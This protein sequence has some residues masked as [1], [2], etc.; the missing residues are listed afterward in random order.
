[1]VIQDFKLAFLNV[2]RHTRRS[3]MTISVGGVGVFSVLMIAGFINA[4]FM[5]LRESII[6]SGIGHIEVRTV[7]S[8]NEFEE[9][10]L[11]FGLD[12]EMR[13][14]LEEFIL[15]Q[16]GVYRILPR[17][18]FE[19]LVSNGDRSI[20]FLG[21]GLNWESEQ[22]FTRIFS[23]YSGMVSGRELEGG[24]FYHGILGEGLANDL[25]VEA[26]QDVT[27]LVNSTETGL[28][29]IDIDVV[30]LYRTGIPE[31][32]KRL[33]YISLGLAQELLLTDKISSI[34]VGLEGI[35]VEEEERALQS[36][37]RGEFSD[38]AVRKWDEIDVFY[39]AVRSL[40]TN[41]FLVISLILGLVVVLSTSTTMIMCVLER[42][43]EMATLRA[44]GFS[45]TNLSLLFCLEGGLLGLFGGIFGV[46]AAWI[47]GDMI[48]GINIMM[49][50]PPGRDFPYP[51]QFIITKEMFIAV[52]LINPV[53][54]S[55]SSF[56]PS[57]RATRGN[58]AE[59]LQVQ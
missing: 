16:E 19:G 38:L 49:P 59:S 22:D 18:D 9:E 6:H 25:G 43:K 29:V 39:P 41:I 37:L 56:L 26:G 36:R 7:E 34:S 33:V 52:V 12:S 53:L 20:V 32:D 44:F 11:E 57:L 58:I 4:S 46:I 54:C 40:Y 48:N 50:P 23:L 14:K 47:L 51:L 31:Y 28:N 35:G 30:G 45:R 17:I 5:G 27:L 24:D 2:L 3:L 21:K 13:G 8:L 55:I 42:Q 10:T 15:S 1:M